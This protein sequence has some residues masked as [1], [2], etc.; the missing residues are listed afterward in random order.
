MKP[1]NLWLILLANALVL[2]AHAAIGY[3]VPGAVYTQSFDSLAATGTNNAW[4]NDATLPGWFWYSGSGVTPAIYSA[5]NGSGSAQNQP[6]SLGASGVA[7]RALG[8]Q[9]PSST[10][11][12]PTA[13]PAQPI[14]F[15]LILRND[16]GL[17]QTTFNLAYAGEQWREPAT[18][19]TSFESGGDQ[20]TLD[21]QVFPA[22]ASLLAAG[23]WS[24]LPA[25][26]FTCPQNP[27]AAA[28]QYDGNLPANRAVF[29]AVVTNLS[30]P[31]GQ[32][33]LLRWTDR[34]N[35]A[36]PRQFRAMMGV[37]D[38]V[39]STGTNVT[40]ALAPPPVLHANQSIRLLPGESR[41]LMVGGAGFQPGAVLQSWPVTAG[42]GFGNLMVLNA[43]NLSLT[44]TAATNL[45]PGAYGLLV[46]NPDGQSAS[47]LDACVIL[48]AAGQE[49]V[50][51]DLCVYGGSGA[52]V[53]AAVQA[54]RMGKSVAL[55]EPGWHLGGMSIEGLGGT[56]IDNHADFQNS[57]AVGGLA[58]D[59]YRRVSDRYGQRAAFDAMVAAGARNSALWKFEPQVAEAVMEDLVRE[60]GVMVY[61]GHRLAETN[62]VELAA[63]PARLTLLRADN[64]RMF[65]ARMFVDATIEG[66][67]LAAAGVT[68]VIGREANATYG[69][70]KNGIRTTNTYAQFAVRVDPYR[71]P[72]DPGS[73]L[74]P[75]VQDE[76]LGNAGDGDA[77]IQGY[78]F[79]MVLT[80]VAT[81]RIPFTPPAGY[82][83]ANY[84]IYRR[85]AAAGGQLW[86]PGGGVPNGKTD[87]GSWH[88]LSANL[89]G[90]NHGY[91]G[92]GPAVRARVFREHLDFTRG[93]CWFLANDPAV[94]ASVRNEWALWGVCR[95]EFPDHQGWPRR[96]YVR[97]ARRM[98]SD[99]VLAEAHTR[100]VDPA[101]VA[102]PVGLAFW[103]PDTH[104]VRRIVQNGAAYNEGFVFGGSDWAPF[105]IAYRALTP[106]SQECVNLL[107]PTCPS[108]SH[109]AYGAIRIE[110]T[111]MVLGQS[112]ATA[113]CL[114]MDDGVTVQEVDYSRLRARLLADGQVLAVAAP[115]G[116][117]VDNED[118][119]RVVLTGTWTPS[120]YMPGYI[121]SNYLHDGGGSVKESKSITYT[122]GLTNTGVY[123]VEAIWSADANRATNVPVEIVFAGG[124][125]NLLVNQQVNNQ[126]WTRLGV[127]P[128]A[129]GTNGHVTLRND[130]T[131]GYVMADAVRFL[132]VT[133]DSRNR[134]S[135][136][137]PPAWPPDGHFQAG[138]LGTP[139][140]SYTVEQATNL[141]G[142]WLALTNLPAGT[143]G[144]F[145][146]QDTLLPV[147]PRR[148]YRTQLAP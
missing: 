2:T 142:P 133:N 13:I 128:F 32:D 76:P 61:R 121:G 97:D 117:V 102:D 46:T 95:D 59:F 115:A 48:A 130:G 65:A 20:L 124:V 3:G 82:D 57:V 11:T 85:Y 113:A 134:F 119:A 75:T 69:E 93:L 114:A 12:P 23:G 101:P 78:C 41:E 140:F 39:F 100:R 123:A 147:V 96:F 35:S 42:L 86:L 55:V 25:L 91:P 99:L 138:F 47:A 34:N 109:I 43:S 49:L 67:L 19:S 51:A 84:E 80:K 58:L 131:A 89:Y 30:W 64:G 56:D 31:P 74:I 18:N 141:T 83:P 4:G 148:F 60:A 9:S 38:V 40:T 137:T 16:T 68:T 81:N 94:P 70:T 125:T 132:R 98:V 90:L 111:F 112:V 104:H 144:R 120:T 6:L 29:S 36:A 7:E 54:A 26:T 136:V 15:G 14:R 45:A 105:G 63:N 92:G 62:G 24:A 146:L 129:A 108:S 28:A 106:R 44:V 79:R 139:G 8:S 73:G 127:F 126:V 143:D 77:R 17:T 37:D 53:M 87:V 5:T 116:V 22:G 135:L 103:P 52:G 10:G 145:Y 21:C 107:T 33:L 50:S 1:L 110:W 118:V 72:G 122:P 88:D 27:T 71:V 66:D